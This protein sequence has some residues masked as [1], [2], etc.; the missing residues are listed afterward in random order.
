MRGGT[1]GDP[2]ALQPARPPQ[3]LTILLPQDGSLLPEEGSPAGAGSQVRSRD[4][5][6]PPGHFPQ[7]LGISWGWGAEL[8]KGH[9]RTCTPQQGPPSPKPFSSTLSWFG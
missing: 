7:V 4:N 9:S 6:V 2:R 3:A 5:G 8:G 1:A